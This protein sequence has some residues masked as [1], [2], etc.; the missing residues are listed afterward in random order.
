MKTN[1]FLGGLLVVCLIAIVLFLILLVGLI[2]K[3]YR[4]AKKSL[5]FYFFMADLNEKQRKILKELDK[6]HV[7]FSEL[8]T[9]II[10]HDDEED[11][12]L[13][14]KK[15]SQPSIIKEAL[16]SGIPEWRIKILR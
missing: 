11:A 15:H 13:S 5:I 10:G 8:L 1:S 9:N 3:I 16:S 6:C 2:N 4:Q 14:W 12:V 7:S